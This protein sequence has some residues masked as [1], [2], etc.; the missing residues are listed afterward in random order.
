[1]LVNYITIALRG[2]RKN[3]LI[4]AIE[5]LG[6]AIGMSVGLVLII[7]LKSQFSFDKFHPEVQD[8]YRIITTVTNA[9]GG[10][11]EFATTPLA[12]RNALDSYPFIQGIV[13]L[14]P[15][16]TA[17]VRIGNE[18]FPAR[19]AFTDN[20]FFRFFGFPLDE[21]H[22]PNPLQEPNTVVLSEGAARRFFGKTDPIGQTISFDK[23]GLFTVTGVFKTKGYR[24]HIDYELLISLSSVPLLEAG[25]KIDTASNTWDHYD[26]SYNY[27]MLL[28]KEDRENLRASLV[29]LG[30]KSSK[31]LRLPGKL[32]LS[33][34]YQRIDKV[35][36]SS[37]VFESGKGISTQFLWIIGAIAASVLFMSMINY[38]N[39]SVAR[40]LNRATEVGM[41]KVSGASRPELFFQLIVETIVRC[42][43]AMLI[44][45]VVCLLLPFEG[46]LENSSWKESF[47]ISLICYFLMYSIFVGTLSGII[48]AL[49]LSRI[50]PI[51][52]LNRF[53]NNTFIREMALGKPL[54]GFQFTISLV[55]VIGLLVMYNQS[56]FMKTSDYGFDRKNI[57][58]LELRG[59]NSGVINTELAR[60]AGV[61]NT[62]LTSG[63]M[64]IGHSG[65]VAFATTKALAEPVELDYI[66][67]DSAL[68][69]SMKIAMIAGSNFPAVVPRVERYVIINETAVQ[70]LGLKTPT[71]SIGRTVTV[72]DSVD[73]EVVGVVKDF[74]YQS[75]KFP[76][77]SF[78]FRQKPDEYRYLNV[79]LISE[80]NEDF[81]T[82]AR[83][84]WS[85]TGSTQELL[86]TRYDAVFS[87][88]QSYKK[89]LKTVGTFSVMALIIS[90]IG[91]FGIT[92]H[93][94]QKR[95]KEIGI[96]KVFGGSPFQIIA[97]LTKRF[98]VLLLIS[99]VIGS[100]VGY[101]LAYQLV[102]EFTYRAPI[103]ITLIALAIVLIDGV[104]LL[105][106]TS[107]SYKAASADPIKTIRID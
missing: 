52:S 58:L 60:Y 17:A 72:D 68:I 32:S 5:I 106:I 40:S 101:F 73:L 41:R 97:M 85:K 23:T 9:E 27:V 22:T 37:L 44:S 96:R 105:I 89:D 19:A 82:F 98:M 25:K 31:L 48:P 94:L 56:D 59:V 57:Y 30:Q 21:G 35:Y 71:E 102:Q 36:P 7:A 77:R 87:E 81:M 33:F 4:S 64:G 20:D 55:F 93:S 107:Q 12:I 53:A 99:S 10:S 70:T 13:T 100:A 39:L 67:T 62:F 86:L 79:K 84:V 74:N 104:A 8:T 24:S 47:S 65:S 18:V 103:S 11:R 3:K 88:R 16:N 69:P 66:S 61:E 1:M 54:I 63:M 92:M 50:K 46:I 45:I 2:L 29:S 43:L 15:L 78:A 95:T 28:P 75:F 42:I 51:D 14:Y 38:F 90:C 80:A 34:D 26:K 49:A 91:L 76:I 83:K 6:L